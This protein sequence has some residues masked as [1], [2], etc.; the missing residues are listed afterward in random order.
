MLRV[1][2]S[3]FLNLSNHRL[4]EWSEEQKHAALLLVSAN[5][6][7]DC[8]L[9]MVDPRSETAE[10]IEDADGVISA[11]IEQHGELKKSVG[12]AMV[13]GEPIFTVLLIKRLQSEGIRCFSAT[14]ERLTST[15]EGV[16]RSRFSFVKFREWCSL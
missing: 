9:P 14:T 5:S 13:A 8:P 6:L 7:I 15:D 4:I 16:K 12:G 1:S 3:L 11:L 2:R 10:L